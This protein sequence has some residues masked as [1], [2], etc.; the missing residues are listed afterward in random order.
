VLADAVRLLEPAGAGVDDRLAAFAEASPGEPVDLGSEGPVAVARIDVDGAESAVL[1]VS[2]A[3]AA[4]GDV[5][6]AAEEIL[7]DL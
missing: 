5:Q 6:A 2:C 7:A 1:Y 4:P 3:S